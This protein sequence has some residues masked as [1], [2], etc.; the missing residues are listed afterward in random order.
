MNDVNTRHALSHE[1]DFHAWSQ[2]QGRRLREIRPDNIDWVNV[3]EEIEGLGRSQRSEIRSRLI[4]ALAHLL[5]WAHQPDGRNNSWRA[6]IVGARNEILHEL[7]D[8]ASLRRYPGEVLTRQ[9]PVARLD[10]S[11]DTGLALET[12]P[13]V[14]PFTIE[15]ILDPDFWPDAPQG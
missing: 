6:S 5:K 8:S 15:Q 12:F 9:Y 7:S 3:A 2:D 1:R 11:G 14:C 10:A 13:E 4:V